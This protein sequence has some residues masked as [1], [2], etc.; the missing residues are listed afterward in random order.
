MPQPACSIPARITASAASSPAS[1][2]P[3]DRA[4]SAASRPIS[5]AFSCASASQSPLFRPPARRAH[6]GRPRRCG[7][8]LADLLVHLRD[9]LA[10]R[11][12]LRM[13]GDLPP[14][15]GHLPGS[16]LPATVPPPAGG[17]GPQEPR[18]VPGMIRLRARAVRLPALA[19]VLAHRPAPEVT[20]RAEL[21]IQPLPLGLQLREATARSWALL[22]WLCINNQ[23]PIITCPDVGPLHMCRAPACEC[24]CH[25][26]RFPAAGLPGACR[27]ALKSGRVRQ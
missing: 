22:I 10:D 23:T 11:R 2:Q 1:P 8:G 24:R 26:S 14:H 5:A 25:L 15:L 19:V 18:P 20:D 17:P 9:L 12:E 13:P 3:S 7:P 21:R 16:Q 6:R 27:R 4:A